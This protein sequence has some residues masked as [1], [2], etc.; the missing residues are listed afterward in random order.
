MT[1]R[2]RF[3]SA[4]QQVLGGPRPPPRRTLGVGS[5]ALAVELS[6]AYTER[7]EPDETFDIWGDETDRAAELLAQMPRQRRRRLVRWWQIED[8]VPNPVVLGAARSLTTVRGTWLLA[9][10]NV[11]PHQAWCDGAV[12]DWSVY[13][14]LSP[15]E[16]LQWVQSSLGG[17]HQDTAELLIDRCGTSTTALRSS[18]A[19]VRLV[20]DGH[21]TPDDVDALVT[22]DAGRDY[23]AAL[24][25]G[26][27]RAALRAVGQVPDARKALGLL[28]W[29]LADLWA[30][31]ELRPGAAQRP[32]RES[33]EITGLPRW[34]V[35]DLAPLAR[36]YP[37]ARVSACLEAVAVAHVGLVQSPDRPASVLRVLAAMW[38]KGR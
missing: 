24:L 26:D 10:S 5:H 7:L 13:L 8:A 35:E 2:S 30:L 25:A 9:T 19:L 15:A 27:A 34:V 31:S 22:P 21:P 1:R 12:W 16:R 23:V 4:R 28:Q 29:R 37:R 14:R 18:C 17:A 11:E 3:A 33:A 20:L 36:L 32:V 38:T 6:D